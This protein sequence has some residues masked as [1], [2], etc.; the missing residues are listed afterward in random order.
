MLV[1]R[2]HEIVEL[3]EHLLRERARNGAILGATVAASDQLRKRG[4][5]FVDVE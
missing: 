4:E 5:R 3:V 1:D 2:I